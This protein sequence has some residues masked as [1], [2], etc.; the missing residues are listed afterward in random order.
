MQTWEAPAKTT[1]VISKYLYVGHEA[2][3]GSLYRQLSLQLFCQC[4]VSCCMSLLP[5]QDSISNCC[6]NTEVYKISFAVFLQKQ[7]QS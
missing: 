3:L 6:Y 4:I 7:K 5:L 1:V 2:D